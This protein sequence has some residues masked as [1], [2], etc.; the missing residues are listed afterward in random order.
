[1]LSRRVFLV[2]L[3]LLYL[4]GERLLA[5]RAPLS[6]EELLKNADLI[7]VGEIVDLRVESE[8][9]QI[10][11]GFGNYDWAIYATIR[12]DEIEK[13]QAEGS[14]T[15]VARSF[16]IKSRKSIYESMTPSGNH[17]IPDVGTRVRAYL[18]AHEATWQVIYPNGFQPVSGDDELSDA[19]SVAR[20]KAERYTFLLPLEVWV[21][22]VLVTMLAVAII[23]A[24]RR[25]SAAA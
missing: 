1:M 13:G 9:S 20:L 8:P 18:A 6:Q 10:E 15:L 7:A 11:Q 16:R 5:E 21:A 19:D 12:I 24:R 25:R 2:A 4:S 17:T 14:D 22:G 23:R 3:G